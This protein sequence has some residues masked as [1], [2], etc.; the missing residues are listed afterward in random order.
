MDK[1]NILAKTIVLAID[2]DADFLAT[3]R[4]LLEA[5]DLQ[6]LTASSGAKGL[7]ILNNT[8]QHLRVLLLDYNMP[9]FNGEDTLLHVRQI[10][11]D[12]K[13]I[14]LSGVPASQLPETFRNTVDKLITKPFKLTQLVDAIKELAILHST[15]PVHSFEPVATKPHTPKS[16]PD[17]Q[18]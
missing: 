18:I 12:I 3:L 15:S 9:I 17:I 6:V 7:N 1:K 10:R 14:A 13:I 16:H 11:P 8:S 4:D 5:Q 2:D